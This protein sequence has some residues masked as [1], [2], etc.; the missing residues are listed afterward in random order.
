MVMIFWNG[1]LILVTLENFSWLRI[2]FSLIIAYSVHTDNKWG[3]PIFTNLIT[4]DN[5][6]IVTKI[7]F[8]VTVYLLKI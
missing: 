5:N 7:N 8:T 2:L 1:F 6:L 4:K 3:R